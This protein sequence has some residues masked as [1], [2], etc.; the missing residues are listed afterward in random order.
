MTTL[1]GTDDSNSKGKALSSTRCFGRYRKYFPSVLLAILPVA[2]A[3]NLQSP[4]GYVQSFCM[5]LLKVSASRSSNRVTGD[6]V[7][8]SRGNSF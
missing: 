6:G 5:D 1:T 7:I 4:D 2:C 8:I 3:T